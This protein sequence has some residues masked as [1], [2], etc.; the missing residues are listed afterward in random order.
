MHQ[1]ADLSNHMTSAKLIDKILKIKQF[2]PLPISTEDEGLVLHFF[3]SK[4][5]QN[6]HKLATLCMNEPSGHSLTWAGNFGF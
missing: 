6:S 3:F 5:I 1:N 4:I 2:L